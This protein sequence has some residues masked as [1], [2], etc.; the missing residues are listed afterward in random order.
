MERRREGGGWWRSRAD[1]IV[2]EEVE[3]CTH[4]NGEKGSRAWG[5]KD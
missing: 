5:R 1:L 4:E 3:R 2:L